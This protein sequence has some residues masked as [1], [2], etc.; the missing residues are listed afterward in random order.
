MGVYYYFRVLVFG[1]ASAPTAWGRVAAWLARSAAV[2]IDPKTLRLAIYVDNPLYVAGGRL[3]GRA[4]ECAV[5]P[6]WAT[7]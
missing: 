3:R 7:L 5:A 1:A 6:L 2:L 4:R